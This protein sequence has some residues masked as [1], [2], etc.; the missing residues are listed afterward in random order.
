MARFFWSITRRSR[1]SGL[2]LAPLFYPE[3]LA[4]TVVAVS[5]LLS[6][7]PALAR[8]SRAWLRVGVEGALTEVMGR[9]HRKAFGPKATKEGAVQALRQ[10]VSQ[11]A[12]A[13]WS[14]RH[15]PSNSSPGWRFIRLL[16]RADTVL[17]PAGNCSPHRTRFADDLTWGRQPG[18]RRILPDR[19]LAGLI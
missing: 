16:K 3:R 17:A 15:H 8:E 7:A 11:P 9:V 2:D 10:Q 5:A 12:C 19:G 18:Q 4:A 13:T 14:P 6:S 1:R